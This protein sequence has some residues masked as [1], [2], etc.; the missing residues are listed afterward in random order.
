MGPRPV[1]DDTHRRARPR[2]T[3]TRRRRRTARLLTIVT[4]VVLLA[5]TACG[6]DSA[7]GDVEL[8]FFQFKSEAIDVFDQLIA[9]F[10]S[11]HDGITVTQNAVPDAEAALQVRLVRDD[12]PDLMSL[13]GNGAFGRVAQAGV[14][15]D[16]ADDEALGLVNPAI[17]D[18]LVELG[19]AGDGEVNG[20]PFANNAGGVIYNV[21][22]FAEHD[23]EPPTTWQEL[24]DV[25]ATFEDAGITPFYGT[26]GDSWTALP[27]WNALASTLPPDDFWSQLR[28]DETSFADDHQVVAERLYELFQHTQDNLFERGY[29]DGNQAFAQGESAMYLQGSYTIPAIRGFEPDFEIGTFALP[30]DEADK[31]ELVSGVDVVLTMPRDADHPEEAMAFIDYLLTEDVQRRYAEDQAA[32]PVLEGLSARAALAGRRTGLLRRPAPGGL[33]RP[34]G[35]VGHPAGRRAADVPAQRR[36]RR[37]AHHA[38]HPVGPRR[39]APDPLTPHT[40]PIR[41]EVA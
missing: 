26:L 21:D 32:I 33:R 34:P 30:A 10:E 23:V 17:T 12:I 13:N 24:L 6:S 4:A 15:R 19:T 9:D 31:T 29:D 20:V 27:A 25:I 7:S 16:F 37:A 36:R 38:R 35:P 39:P 8:E 40:P 28:N 18:I 41:Q 11:T 1:H 14:F 22:L 5:T 2:A 3:G